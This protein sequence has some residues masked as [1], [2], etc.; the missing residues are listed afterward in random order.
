MAYLLNEHLQIIHKIYIMI[1]IFRSIMKFSK[2][3]RVK[4]T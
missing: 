4:W 2:Y 3:T 1:L